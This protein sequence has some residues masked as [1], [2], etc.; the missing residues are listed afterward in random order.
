[1]EKRIKVIINKD[2]SDIK[3]KTISG[4]AGADCHGTADQVMAGIGTCTKQGD[5]DDFYKEETPDA[6]VTDFN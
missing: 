2:G 1:M 4:F 6:F 3:F 5:T